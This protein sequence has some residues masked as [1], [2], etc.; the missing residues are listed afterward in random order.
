MIDNQ[1]GRRNLTDGW[2]FELSQ[3]KKAILLEVGKVKNI[4]AGKEG[5][6]GNIKPLSII[7]KPFEQVEKHNTQ[8]TIANDLGWSTGKVA[9]LTHYKKGNFR[10][11][12]G[13]HKK[14]LF[15]TA[16]FMP[17]IAATLADV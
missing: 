8:K 14:G 16:F 6:R 9:T 5:G 1:N 7:D 10:G 11:L 4:E 12:F 15:N 17:K 3:A 2:K 13:V